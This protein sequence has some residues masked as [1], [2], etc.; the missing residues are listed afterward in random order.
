[1]Q[2]SLVALRRWGGKLESA[3]AKF[4]FTTKNMLCIPVYSKDKHIVAVLQFLNKNLAADASRQRKSSSSVG[5]PT[6]PPL[7]AP[8]LSPELVAQFASDDA[9]PWKFFSRRDLEVAAGIADLLG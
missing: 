6:P 7:P 4:K 9:D 5:G 2:E 1:M 8:P 3:D